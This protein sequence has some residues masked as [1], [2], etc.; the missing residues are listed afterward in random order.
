MFTK[1]ESICMSGC[2]GIYTFNLLLKIASIFRKSVN[3]Y[4][5]NGF[6]ETN[7]C[8]NTMWNKYERMKPM[9][10]LF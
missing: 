4:A 1:F 7:E 2:L 9:K 8:F 5:I 10:E 3:I 6:N